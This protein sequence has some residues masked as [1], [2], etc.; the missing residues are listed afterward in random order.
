MTTTDRITVRI[1]EAQLEA[2][3]QLVDDGEFHNRSVAIRAALESLS[4]ES[5]S[6]Q[7]PAGAVDPRR[8]LATD[9]GQTDE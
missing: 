6:T 5:Q 9:G 1:P 8:P 3:D 7:P 4:G 2:V